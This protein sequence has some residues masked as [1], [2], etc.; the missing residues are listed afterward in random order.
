MYSLLLWEN[1]KDYY[2]EY[3]SV[4]LQFSV[5]YYVATCVMSDITIFSQFSKKKLNVKLVF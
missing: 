5:Q 1:N 4:S 3:V 2:S